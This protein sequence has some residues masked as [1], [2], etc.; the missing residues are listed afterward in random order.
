MTIEVVNSEE[1]ET[2]LAEAKTAPSYSPSAPKSLWQGVRGWP[3]LTLAGTIVLALPFLI[4]TYQ[5]SLN[6]FISNNHANQVEKALIAVQRGRL[7]I[8][9]FIY[10]PIPFL[11]IVPYPH[12]LTPS[13]MAAFMAGATAWLLWQRLSVLNFPLVVRVM[14][15]IL[16]FSVPSMIYLATQSIA[17]MM[18][19]LVMVIVWNN[20]ISFTQGGE[21][22]AGFIAGLGLGIGFG[23]NHYSA[24]FG[25][26][27]AL[28]VPLFIRDRRFGPIMATVLVL[29]FPLLLAIFAWS[30]I[31][32]VFVGDPFYF[33]TSPESS[34]FVRSQP[35]DYRLT[36]SFSLAFQTVLEDLLSVPLYMA[37]GVIVAFLH[38]KRLPAY[39]APIFLVIG[40]R[41]L[42][43]AFP[44]YLF[45]GTCTVLALAGIP[46]FTS[47]RLWPLLVVVIILHF[48]VNFVLPVR[49]EVA[50]W[51][52]AML[53]RQPATLD[54]EEQEIAQYVKSFPEKSILLNDGGAN[55]GYR[56]IM[57][58]GTAQ[59]FL[60]PPDALYQIASSQPMSF[61]RYVL[62]PYIPPKDPAST[63]ISTEAAE[64]QQ[65]VPLGFRL[66][67]SW[68]NWRLYELG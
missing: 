57:R 35:S 58:A 50:V 23:V 4:A 18:L 2:S 40:L 30:Y 62:L 43:L 59:P 31:N 19:L 67:K 60:L 13:I 63:G 68:P 49:D 47:A 16:P 36:V 61:V 51:G 5:A 55:S 6:L 32:W 8:I 15:L 66:K 29:A 22:R 52:R 17:E 64:A 38:I 27:F 26:F 11:L 65:R 33:V 7:E 37:V 34:V 48:T 45:I 12:P 21:T 39:L 56:I 28:S 53:D 42:G 9:G 20:F 25:L 24:V 46:R 44:D 14:L 54:L 1:D 41:S 3:W 10:P